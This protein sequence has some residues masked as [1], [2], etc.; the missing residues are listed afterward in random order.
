MAVRGSGRRA[1]DAGSGTPMDREPVDPAVAAAVADRD[2][3]RSNLVDLE[4]SAGAELL[5]R[6]ELSGG[7]RARWEAAVADLA[8]AWQLFGAYSE[9]IDDAVRSPS[10]VHDLLAEPSIVVR[11]APAPLA[12]RH[13]TDDGRTRLTPAAAV[14]QLNQ[15]FRRTAELVTTVELIW[16]EVTHRLDEIPARPDIQEELDRILQT[17]RSD[18]LSLWQEGRVD[19]S[20]LDELRRRSDGR[21]PEPTNRRNDN[22]GASRHLAG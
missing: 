15:L 18:P 5:S 4:G 21:L 17:L 3:I 22:A 6:A 13:I 2:A 14:D 12:E 20:E 11:G 7:T 10:T 1:I 8:A 19:T 16:T 9:V